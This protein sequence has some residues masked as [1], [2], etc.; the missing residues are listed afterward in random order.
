MPTEKPSV[1]LFIFAHPD[2]EFFCLP[3]IECECK[4]GKR[5]LCAYLTDGAYGGQSSDRRMRESLGVLKHCGVEFAN[6]FFPG[7]QLN[8]PDGQLH[9]HAYRAYQ[10]LQHITNHLVIANI[11]VPAWEGGHQD[12]DACHVIGIALAAATGSPQLRQ[13]ALYNGSSGVLPFTVMCPLKQNGPASI[14]RIGLSEAFKHLSR[15]CSYPSQWR[16]WLGLFPFAAL[17][18]LTRRSYALQDISVARIRQRPHEGRLL[19]E[20][21]AK[22]DF[23]EV[24]DA[25]LRLIDQ[26]SSGPLGKL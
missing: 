23:P 7:V 6:V 5:V 18:V 20:R 14:L 11:Y 22:M 26:A 8:I 10:Q 9:L 15:V 24:R 1:S 25:L 21:R 13:F 3:F 2:D 19:Y 16:T 12:H 4:K 17:V